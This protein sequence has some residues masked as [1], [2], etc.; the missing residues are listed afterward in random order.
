ME[1]GN[2]KGHAYVSKKTWK[3]NQARLEAHFLKNQCFVEQVI[4]IKNKL[5]LIINAGQWTS[6]KKMIFFFEMAELIHCLDDNFQ[7]SLQKYE[8]ERLNLPVDLNEP[9]TKYQEYHCYFDGNFNLCDLDFVNKVMDQKNI[10]IKTHMKLPSEELVIFQAKESLSWE[11]WY[12]LVTCFN[13]GEHR[14]HSFSNHT[15][16]IILQER[17]EIMKAEL[18]KFTP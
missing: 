7:H 17:K 5:L 12:F 18:Y 8:Q 1:I 11:E 14:G 2:K 4:S 13:A 16:D 10:A 9:F 15:P 3:R 6:P